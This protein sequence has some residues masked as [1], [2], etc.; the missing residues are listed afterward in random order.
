[1]DKY[2][3]LITRLR[4]DGS[5]LSKE[6]ADAIEELARLD[7]AVRTYIARYKKEAFGNGFVS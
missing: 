4:E 5:T 2:S 1:M 7:A 6:A 3:D